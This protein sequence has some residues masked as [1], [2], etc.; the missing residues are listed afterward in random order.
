MT[1]ILFS[2]GVGVAS[3]LAWAVLGYLCGMLLDWVGAQF[4]GWHAD[5]GKDT[6]SST[7]RVRLRLFRL[8]TGTVIL[9]MFALLALFLYSFGLLVRSL[10][11][12]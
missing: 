8:L 9:S 2:C 7:R 6:K 4:L 3:L 1:D 5:S 10:F 11:D 12:L